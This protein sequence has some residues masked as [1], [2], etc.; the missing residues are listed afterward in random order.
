[1]KRT[2][3]CCLV[4]PRYWSASNTH[5]L[6]CTTESVINLA[7]ICSVYKTLHVTYTIDNIHALLINVMRIFSDI[8]KDGFALSFVN[9]PLREGNV[10]S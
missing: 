1:M 5:P 7:Y 9:M 3:K 10:V 6:L 8:L 2:T 4:L